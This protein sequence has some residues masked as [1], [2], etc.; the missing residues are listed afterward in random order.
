MQTLTVNKLYRVAH[1]DPAGGPQA[2]RKQSGMSRASI[3][4]VGEDDRE[5]IVILET[6]AKRIAPDELINRVFETQE[7]WHPARFGIDASGPQLSFYQLLLKEGRERGIKWTPV[8]ISATMDKNYA[9]ESA[10]QPVAAA[11]RLIRPPDKE[12]Y[13]LADEWR[14]FPDGMYRD[15]LDA[16]SWCIRLL[17][18]VLPAHLRMMGERQL[19]EYLARTGLPQDMIEARIAQRDQFAQK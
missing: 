19:R 4:V 2:G 17:P 9:I 14:A 11:G 13:Q 1:C 15:A 7:R 3:C 10:I 6:W 18:T 12:C 16:L 8:Q 5:R